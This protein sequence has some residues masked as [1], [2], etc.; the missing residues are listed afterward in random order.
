VS[1]KSRAYEWRL[2]PIAAEA[3]SGARESN[4][5]LRYG[6]RK[7]SGRPAAQKVRRAAQANAA[8][9]VGMARERA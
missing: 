6:S 7:A 2:S 3:S 9:V 4:G 8:R 5:T 1:S